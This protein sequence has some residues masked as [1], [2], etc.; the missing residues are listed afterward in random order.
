MSYEL[1]APEHPSYGLLQGGR[2]GFVKSISTVL[3]LHLHP[4]PDV[5]ALRFARSAQRP[6]LKRIV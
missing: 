6:A 4:L 1:E 2:A 5:F 3:E